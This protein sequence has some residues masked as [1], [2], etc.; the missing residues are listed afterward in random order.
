[1]ELKDKKALIK[2]CFEIYTTRVFDTK[3]DNYTCFLDKTKK[4]V[5]KCFN[6]ESVELIED[7]DTYRKA[8]AIRQCLI[9]IVEMVEEINKVNKVDYSPNFT[10]E[11]KKAL[12]ILE[13]LDLEW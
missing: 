8:L 3:G 9:N 6:A 4:L 12:K 11:I 13:T 7:L 2:S 1:M 10:E 5:G